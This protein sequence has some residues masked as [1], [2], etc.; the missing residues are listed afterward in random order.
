MI[1]VKTI[2]N[3]EFKNCCEIHSNCGKAYVIKQNAK[4]INVEVNSPSSS[5]TRREVNTNNEI[6]F[7]DEFEEMIAI[8]HQMY[9]ESENWE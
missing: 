9:D 6:F 4:H 1:T 2:E 8:T 7:H 5:R 3:P